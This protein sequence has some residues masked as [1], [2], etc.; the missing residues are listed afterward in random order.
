MYIYIY[1]YTYIYIYELGAHDWAYAGLPSG[2]SPR[3]C[4]ILTQST[5]AISSRPHLVMNMNIY[6]YI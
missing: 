4:S 6:I 5:S 2:R 1:I 3:C